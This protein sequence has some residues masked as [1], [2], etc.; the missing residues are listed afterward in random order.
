MEKTK[1]MIDRIQNSNINQLQAK[2]NSENP[3]FKGPGILLLRTLNDSPAIGACAV[4]MC[5]MVIPRTRIEWKNRGPQSGIETGIREGT[6]NLIHTCVGLIGLGAATGISKK[7]NNEFN[8]KAQNIFASGSTIDTMAEI[9]RRSGREQKKFLSS[10]VN[11]VQGLDGSNW[12]HISQTSKKE[13]TDSLV[14]LAEKTKQL[15]SATGANKK[16]IAKEIKTLKASIVGRVIK[17]TGAQASFI[18]PA[19]C[20]ANKAIKASFSELVDNAVAVSNSFTTQTKE[21]LPKF[22]NAL[23]KNKTAATAL[24]MG[25]CAALCISVQPI[26]R[27]LTKLR[28][29]KDGFVGV[30][31]N[32]ETEVKGNKKK[33]QLYKPLK[34][35]LGVAFPAAALRTIGKYSDL[36]SNIQFNSKVPTINQFKFLYGLTIASRFMSARD[37]NELRESVIKDTLGFTNW[38]ILGGM[39][40]KLVARGIG[41]KELINNPVTQTGAK[42]GLKYAGQ[43]LTKASV[44]SFDEVLL[45][46]AGEIM[47]GNKMMKFSQLFKN[48]DAATKTK[49]LKIGASQLAG[50]LY[51]GFVL[52]VGIAKLNIAVTRY[53][54]NKKKAQDQMDYKIDENS[55]IKNNKTLSKLENNNPIFKDFN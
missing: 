41:G 40:S 34:M 51:S 11:R 45:P 31:T 39:V 42:K 28:T 23:K 35:I 21:N 29:G 4:D 25:I 37:G 33:F 24:G 2:H 14:L 10:F 9:W 3:S 53:L 8:I 30:E 1:R 20:K 18:I 12:R 43:W 13:I 49:V 38:L 47:K 7:F 19:P 5:S 22:I 26:N 44:K 48:A 32:N 52:G 54:N 17:D 15:A 36:L 6:S 46:K 27:L 55:P 50:Y 16:S